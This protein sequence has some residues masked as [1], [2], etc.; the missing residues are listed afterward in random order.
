MEGGPLSPGQRYHFVAGWLP[1][2]ADGCNLLFNL[3]ALGWSVAMVWAPKQIEPPLVMYSVLPLSLFTFKL[4]KLAHLYHV[5]VG[6]NVRQTLARRS[7]AGAHPH[8]RQSGG[9]GSGHEERAVLPHTQAGERLG[10]AARAGGRTRGDADDARPHAVGVAVAH[11]V[12]TEGRDPLVG[13]GPARLDR[14]TARSVRAV[15]LRVAG[16]T[17]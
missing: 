7:P 1:W 5:R 13:S 8:H 16:I 12:P 3:A 15:R 10:P 17:R 4:A 6:A 2:V 9:E 11:F 14:G